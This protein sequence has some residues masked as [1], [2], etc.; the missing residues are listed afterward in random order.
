MWMIGNLLSE[1]EARRTSIPLN[2]LPFLESCLNEGKCI[3]INGAVA[4][5]LVI[6]SNNSW[7]DR[8]LRKSFWSTPSAPAMESEF[9]R[10]LH[11]FKII[12][13]VV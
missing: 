5:D 12:K 1:K 7:L 9:I 8:I 10:I 13:C 4:K 11:F 6:S 2:T 3:S